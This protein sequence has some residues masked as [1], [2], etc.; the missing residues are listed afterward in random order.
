MARYIES[1]GVQEQGIWFLRVVAA[2]CKPFCKKAKLAGA[3][4][5]IQAAR[6]THPEHARIQ[7]CANACTEVFAHFAGSASASPQVTPPGTPLAPAEQKKSSAKK[8]LLS[9]FKRS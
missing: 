3:E 8:K 7:V 1:A 6:D 9:L 4:A 5:T 2:H